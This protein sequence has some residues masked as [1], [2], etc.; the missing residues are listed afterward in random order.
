MH[1]VSGHMSHAV[2]REVSRAEGSHEPQLPPFRIIGMVHGCC[3]EFCGA[4]HSFYLSLVPTV[5]RLVVLSPAK[6]ATTRTSIY[7]TED[8]ACPQC[9]TVFVLPAVTPEAKVA[10][11]VLGILADEVSVEISKF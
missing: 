8:S 10:K 4:Q 1:V 7:G 11:L 9:Q 6:W 5:T 2:N 3:K